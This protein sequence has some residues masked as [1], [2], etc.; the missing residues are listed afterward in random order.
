MEGWTRNNL[1]TSFDARLSRWESNFPEVFRGTR[2]NI[3]KSV[4]GARGQLFLFFLLR[5]MSVILLGKRKKTSWK[6]GSMLRHVSVT[7]LY[8][9]NTYNFTLLAGCALQ[10]SSLV[11]LANY[12][13][14]CKCRVSNPKREN[15]HCEIGIGIKKKMFLSIW[16]EKSSVSYCALFFFIWLIVF[17]WGSCYNMGD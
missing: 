2:R 10:F 17:S 4:P 3:Q 6:T 12:S 16:L 7:V 14:M 1:I 9:R 11:F 15:V 5:E 13:H 8:D